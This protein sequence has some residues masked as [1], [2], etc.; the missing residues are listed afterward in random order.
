MQINTKCL[1][2]L[3]INLHP[4][5]TIGAQIAIGYKGHKIYESNMKPRALVSWKIPLLNYCIPKER[6]SKSRKCGFTCRAKKAFAKKVA[7]GGNMIP[8][9][10][11]A[12]EARAKS[13]GLKIGGGG[14]PFSGDWATK[15]LYA[16]NGGSYNGIAFFGTGGTAAQMRSTANLKADQY[17]PFDINYVNSAEHGMKVQTE[18]STTTTTATTATIPAAAATTQAAEAERRMQLQTDYEDTDDAT[19]PFNHHDVEDTD[20]GGLESDSTGITWFGDA[21]CPDH[22]QGPMTMSFSMQFLD[23]NL[24]NTTQIILTASRNVTV[25]SDSSINP[26]TEEPYYMYELTNIQQTYQMFSELQPGFNGNMTHWN[27]SD[28]DAQYAAA[29]NSTL[30]PYVIAK[31]LTISVDE[32]DSTDITVTSKEMFCGSVKLYAKRWNDDNTTFQ[33]FAAGGGEEQVSLIDKL[34]AYAI[35]VPI[36]CVIALAVVVVVI[37]VQ[38]KKAQAVHGAEWAKSKQDLEPIID[39]DAAAVD[40][41]DMRTAAL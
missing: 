40:S 14:Y 4:I 32:N 22:P 28:P 16:Y 6:D 33:V 41:V 25:D 5:I 39:Q 15:G 37:V 21:S 30:A 36:L 3:Q 1:L 18:D 13:L 10:V 20:Q 24:T 35:Y 34:K 12:G 29:V 17:R 7:H 9:T 8:L 2:L 27:E 38:K 19:Q 11:S 31:T 26:E 23:G